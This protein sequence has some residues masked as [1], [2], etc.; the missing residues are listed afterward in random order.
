MRKFHKPIRM[1]IACK[2]RDYQHL[3]RRFACIDARLVLEPKNTRSFY[4]CDDCLST[5]DE[6]IL[7]KILSRFIKISPASL[8]EILNYA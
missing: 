1:C 6:K 2:K 7:S 4:L 3:L 8:K 5:K